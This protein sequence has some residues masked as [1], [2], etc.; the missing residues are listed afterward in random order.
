MPQRP[1]DAKVHKG[2]QPAALKYCAPCFVVQSKIVNLK[3]TIILSPK[4]K[5]LEFP[6]RPG[7]FEIKRLS[8]SFAMNN[9]FR[10]C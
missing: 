5:D 7:Y 3:S 8:T 9:G 6:H 1:K 2:R 10:F 4:S